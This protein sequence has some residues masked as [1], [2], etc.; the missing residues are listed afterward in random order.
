MKK[1]A[2]AAVVVF[3][4][5]AAVTVAYSADTKKGMAFPKDWETYK[6]IGSLVI[7]DKSHALFGIHHFY[8]NNKGAKAFEK[9]EKYPDG[10]I[11]FDAV[12]ELKQDGAILNEGKVAFY[13]VMKKN[14]KMK[15]TGGWEWAAFGPDRKPLAIDPKKDCFSCHEPMK[16]NDYV[17]SK[18]LK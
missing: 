18:P 10:T 3:A 13:P 6:H 7:T 2:W 11:I 5:M 16:D 1:L 17:F 4:V 15:E 8:I 12:Y 9:G 14:A